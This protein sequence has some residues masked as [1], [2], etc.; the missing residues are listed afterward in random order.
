MTICYGAGCARRHAGMTLVELLAAIGLIG[1]LASIIVAATAE[2]RQSFYKADEASSVRQLTQGYLLYAE[3]NGGRVIVGRP[4]LRSIAMTG[5]ELV[6]HY[7]HPVVDSEAKSRYV[8]RLLP[9]IGEIRVFFPGQ[10]R[11]FVSDVA[12]HSQEDYM[13]TLCPTFG[14]NETYLG[15]NEQSNFWNNQLESLIH[16]HD[17]VNPATLIVF[18]S[19]LQGPANTTGVTDGD[20]YV[21]LYRVAPPNGSNR[22]GSWVGRNYDNTI[23]STLGYIRLDED[24]KAMVSHLDGSVTSLDQQQ[25]EDMRRWSNRAALLNKSSYKPSGVFY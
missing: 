19:T 5:L 24:G 18:V 8:F 7:G 15:G 4:S 10:A 11:R 23:P 20:Y 21:G 6:N 16:T 17:A 25:L 9:Y 14:L 2:V 3:D 22:D 1:I 13:I 12:G